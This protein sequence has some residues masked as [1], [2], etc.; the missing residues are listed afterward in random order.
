MGSLL[1]RHTL[2]PPNSDRFSAPPLMWRMRQLRVTG[3]WCVSQQCAAGGIKVAC[4]DRSLPALVIPPR[5]RPGERPVR[6]QLLLHHHARGRPCHSLAGRR[7][8]GD[9]G[10]AHWHRG[11]GRRR[12]ADGGGESRRRRGRRRRCGGAGGVGGVPGDAGRGEQGVG[13]GCPGRWPPGARARRRPQAQR[14]GLLQRPRD[15]PASESS[16]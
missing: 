15:T 2:H 4:Q 11:E 8:R 12:L 5:R 9:G 16:F 1:G 7:P 13:D 10:G 3:L 14:L 6:L